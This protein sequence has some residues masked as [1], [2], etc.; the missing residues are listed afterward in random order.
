MHSLC[1]N[2][3]ALY[4]DLTGNKTYHGFL[5]VEHTHNNYVVNAFVA[6]LSKG[7][8]G[9]NVFAISINH[10]YGESAQP[11]GTMAKGE[12]HIAIIVLC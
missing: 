10:D 1:L 11:Y 5:Y 9:R 8:Q 4:N 3:Y 12:S 7:Q 6:L 2:F